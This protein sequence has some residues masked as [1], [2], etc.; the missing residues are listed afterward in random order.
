LNRLLAGAGVV[1]LLLATSPE[2]FALLAAEALPERMELA[3]AVYSAQDNR[4]IDHAEIQLCD[5]RGTPLEMHVSDDSGQFSFRGLP[6]AAYQLS[7]SAVG[8]ERQDQ[9][10]DLSF[11]SEFG[12]SIYLKPD[13]DKL[14]RAAPG[15]AVSAHEMTIPQDA[16]D[17]VA[18][19]KKKMWSDK[20]LE[21]GIADL[22]QVTAATPDYYEA[23]CEIGLG[24][25]MM[26]KTT[27]AEANF[28]KSLEI[29]G[30]RYGDAEVGLG[31]TLINKGDIAGGEEALR[32]GV[33]ASP[34]S[35]L[36]RYEL[37][38]VELSQNHI[39]DAEKLA[40]QARSLAPNFPSVYRLLSSIHLRQK[41]YPA[42]LH[43][44]DAYLQLDPDSPA[45]VRAKQL[46]DEIRQKM[47][48]E[49]AA[50]PRSIA[51]Q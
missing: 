17:R 24:Y 5:S 23:Y 32:R 3:G 34:N 37:S 21:A 11:S 39:A 31:S 4:R 40:E 38:K 8:F 19:A 10:V 50:T 29:S 25:L 18:A 35:W 1:T 6:A 33:E 43:D 41:N 48:T 13:S 27:D 15:A 2:R 45:G 22:R 49:V 44:I 20:N 16:R 26:G 46:R 30:G 28:R 42:L 12:I 36:G 47:T 7:V 51:P 14:K 9:R